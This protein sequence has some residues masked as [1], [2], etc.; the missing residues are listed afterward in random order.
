M[1]VYLHEIREDQE[2]VLQFN[3]DTQWVSDV[4]ASLDEKMHQV[5]R[6]PG[7]KPKRRAITAEFRMRKIDEL[8]HVEGKLDSQ[9]NL[10][11]SLC[12]DGF[13]FPIQTAFHVL[14]TKN[15]TYLAQA[16]DSG[17]G[18]PEVQRVFGKQT[19]S[20]AEG[21]GA[22]DYEVNLVEGNTIDLAELL[23]E[24]ALLLIPMQPKPEFD[25]DERCRKCGLT[26][27]ELQNNALKAKFAEDDS[28]E[29]TNPFNVLKD[30]FPKK[31]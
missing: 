20:D 28:D 21:D 26:R 7:W 30:L 2:F 3:E 23:H 9:V 27:D 15:K 6:P 19:H 18:E 4:I 17:R 29:K 31:K 11:C 25:E 14:F 13:Q 5:T 10:L 12:A 16:D 22:I 8:Y 24:Q 1:K